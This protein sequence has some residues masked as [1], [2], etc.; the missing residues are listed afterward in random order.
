MMWEM[1]IQ[2]AAIYNRLPVM[3]N[4][5]R[6]TGALIYYRATKNNT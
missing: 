4:G 6:R 5:G 2:T 3:I 1:P